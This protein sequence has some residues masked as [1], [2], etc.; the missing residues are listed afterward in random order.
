MIEFV[1]EYGVK[2][3]HGVVDW[4]S[5]GRPEDSLPDA[6]YFLDTFSAEGASLMERLVTKGREVNHE[7]LCS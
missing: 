5:D 2:D 3:V 7:W 6:L 1:C 4:F